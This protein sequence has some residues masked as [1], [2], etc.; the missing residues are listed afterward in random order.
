MNPNNLVRLIAIPIFA[1]TTLGSG[2]AYR[3][4]DQKREIVTTEVDKTTLVLRVDETENRILAGS[5]KG[6]LIAGLADKGNHVLVGAMMDPTGKPF[7]AVGSAEPGA[8][9]GVVL[10]KLSDDGEPALLVSGKSGT[11]HI[12]AGTGPNGA[13]NITVVAGNESTGP[14]LRLGMAETPE[15]KSPRI[16][17]KADGR[18]FAHSLGFSE[19]KY[20]FLEM[21]DSKGRAR[22][23]I[24]V[25]EDDAPYI[26]LL[27]ES[28]KVSWSAR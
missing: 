19:G 16:S 6:R 26:E 15:G 7:L 18:Q 4:A 21:T 5:D 22:V 14:R 24:G 8:G 11:D 25:G 10:L 20:P 23:R 1:V 27:D 12:L 3:A 2:C 28:G 17:M 9:K 13:A